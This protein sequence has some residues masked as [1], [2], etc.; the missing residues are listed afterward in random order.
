MHQ[1]LKPAFVKE[2]QVDIK[3]CQTQTSIT[4]VTPHPVLL[5]CCCCGAV[6]VLLW[7]CCPAR[8]VCCLQCLQCLSH[9]RVLQ[10]VTESLRTSYEGHTLVAALSTGR[11]YATSFHP[12]APALVPGGEV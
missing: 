10:A 1:S 8:P 6:V 2:F 4:P 12:E 5:L 7:C 9:W 11:V 3:K